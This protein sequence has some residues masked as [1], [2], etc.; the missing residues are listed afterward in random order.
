MILIG[1]VER[2]AFD[3]REAS[4]GD[5]NGYY[6]GIDEIR[7]ANYGSLLVENNRFVSSL[8]SFKDLADLADG[9]SSEVTSL[10][11]KDKYVLWSKELVSSEY[12]SEKIHDF[13]SKK[14]VKG[15]LGQMKRIQSLDEDLYGALDDVLY[16]IQDKETF[17]MQSFRRDLK[18]IRSQGFNDVLVTTPIV[19]REARKHP[20][21][22]I[23]IVRP[24]RN[25]SNF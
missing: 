14:I 11:R 4:K 17:Q 12:L 9:L 22:L 1:D 6:P 2:F 13:V 15:L 16:F 5:D 23:N 8:E 3:I 21:K 18:K 24:S 7:E 19:E 10:K 20:M 25:Y